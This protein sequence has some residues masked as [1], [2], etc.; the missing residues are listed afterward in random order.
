MPAVEFT[1][2]TAVAAYLRA[3]SADQDTTDAVEA[4]NAWLAK[5]DGLTETDDTGAV[6]PTKPAKLGAKMLAARLVRRRNSPAG[7]EAFTPDA[8]LY[9]TRHDPDVA[10]LLGLDAP[11]IG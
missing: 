4:V 9:V 10:L 3:A 1:T 2:A 8:A 7:I 6:V 5:A 11:G